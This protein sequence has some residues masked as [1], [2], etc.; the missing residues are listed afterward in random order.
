MHAGHTLLRHSEFA[1]EESRLGEGKQLPEGAH[2]AVI[3]VA[4]VSEH[5]CVRHCID[6]FACTRQHS[7]VG[8]ILLVCK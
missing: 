5:V 6:D 1:G 3:P 4:D 7:E 2:R 8:I